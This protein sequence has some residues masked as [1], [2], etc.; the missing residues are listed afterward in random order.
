MK[1]AIR[2]QFE[3]GDGG[4]CDEEILSLDKPHDQ[5]EG[6]GLSLAEARR[7][8]STTLRHRRLGFTEQAVGS[9]PRPAG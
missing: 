6:L 1:I 5:L 9:Q 7:N 8:L 2:L 3:A 4:P